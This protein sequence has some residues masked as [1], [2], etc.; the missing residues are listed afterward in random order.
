MTKFLTLQTEIVGQIDQYLR[1]DFSSN[2]SREWCAEDSFK[3]ESECFCAR[4]RSHQLQKQ[5]TKVWWVVL[6]SFRAKA[7]K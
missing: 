7:G 2:H 4:V 1:L 6:I 5:K 3:R